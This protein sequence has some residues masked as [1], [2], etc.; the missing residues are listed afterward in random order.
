MLS[1]GKYFIT[2]V[3]FNNAMDPSMAVCSDGVTYSI[4]SP[5]ISHV[6]VNNLHVLAGLVKDVDGN[7]LY[8][9]RNVHVHEVQNENETDCM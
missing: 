2:V 9:D 3:A 1:S 7:L 4:T 5:E 8:V 6:S